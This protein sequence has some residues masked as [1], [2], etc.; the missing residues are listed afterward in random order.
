[1]NKRTIGNVRV[2]FSRQ[3]SEPTGEELMQRT[4]NQHYVSQFHLKKHERDGSTIWV[5]DKESRRV[6]ST[7]TRNVQRM[8][9]T[10]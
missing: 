2:S 3:R 5:F 10:I 9:S 7:D 8:G 4:K 6:F 1:M